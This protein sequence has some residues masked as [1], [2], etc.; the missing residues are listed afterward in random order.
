MHGPA[1]EPVKKT[2]FNA[3]TAE[4]AERNPRNSLR[5]RRALCQNVVFV[6]HAPRPLLRR[7]RRTWRTTAWLPRR[8]ERRTG[9][10]RGDGGAG[11]SVRPHLLQE[12]LVSH[13]SAGRRRLGTRRELQHRGDCRLSRD[14]VRD[15]V[16]DP[17]G[18]LSARGTL[19]PRDAADVPATPD[20]ARRRHR[21]G[22]VVGLDLRH[23]LP[24]RERGQ[25]PERL[26]PG[27]TEGTR[28][29]GGGRSAG[30]GA[31]NRSIR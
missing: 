29:A 24:R 2:T 23:P 18:D 31:V 21:A 4:I 30:L 28:K 1:R 25:S 8:F 11:D 27:M 19:L 14:A 3:E 16:G 5:A 22:D 26:S 12:S 13:Q 10:K 7:T 20:S 17:P 6:Q 9:Q 15:R